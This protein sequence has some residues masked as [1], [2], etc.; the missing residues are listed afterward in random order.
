MTISSRTIGAYRLVAGLGQ[1]G[2]ARVYLA[3]S[4]KQGGFNKLLVLKVLR[5]DLGGDADFLQ[6]F[7]QEARLAARLNHPHVVQTYEIGDDA[8]RHFIAM[9]YLEGQALSAVLARVGRGAMP[10]DLH[11]RILCDALDGLHYAHEMTDFDGTP[12]HIVHRDVS[13]QNVFVTY[14]GQSKLLD[15]GIA[16][17]AGT[18][19]TQQGVIKGKTGYMAPEQAL[20]TAIDRRADVF[21]V[22]VMLWEALARRRLVEKTD[23]D[24]SALTRRIT[25][26]DPRVRDVAPEAVLELAAICDKAMAKEPADRYATAADMQAAL[27]AWLKAQP[28]AS[29]ARAVA[30]LL[31][32][33]FADD[34]TRIRK[35]VDEQVKRASD[36]GPMI[37]IF[38]QNTVTPPSVDEVPVELGGETAVAPSAPGR[39]RV[40]IF[41]AIG[42]VVVALG[43]VAVLAGRG[44]DKRDAQTAVSASASPTVSAAPAATSAAPP[45]TALAKVRVTLE[46]QPPVA[47]LTL[48]G[49][50]VGNPQSLDVERDG[51]H[52]VVR[53]S[54]PGFA[55]EERA[56]DWD[57]DQSVAFALKPATG[58]A[59]TATDAVD[60]STQRTKRVKRTVDDKDPYQ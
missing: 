6:M 21:A 15:F 52:H 58:P 12:L 57:R 17:V 56:V 5:S 9:E 10:L 45:P 24:V 14:T 37:D 19:R 31:A 13:P 43:A 8:S 44:G 50:P 54:A 30:A 38:T 47:Q 26:N 33:Q 36:A 22:G 28:G 20:G 49:K 23:D 29:D 42:A 40:A 53:A 39:S 7:L 60:L 59:P 27:E 4:Q 32:Q 35:L 18:T 41:A 55:P 25:G 51:S 34:R 16:K 2:M 48:D 1:G 11:V 46:A 3:L